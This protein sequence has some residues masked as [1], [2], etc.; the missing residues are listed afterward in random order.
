MR[1]TMGEQNVS[2]RGMMYNL[3]YIGINKWNK[4][5]PFDKSSLSL[6]NEITLAPE[7]QT[8]VLLYWRKFKIQGEIYFKCRMKNINLLSDK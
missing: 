5:Y 4:L 2:K 7:F 3:K 1:E 8:R 6:R